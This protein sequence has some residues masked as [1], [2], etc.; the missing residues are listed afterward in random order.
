M[1]CDYCGKKGRKGLRGG[2]ERGILISSD[3]RARKG[4]REKGRERG[5]KVKT[6]YSAQTQGRCKQDRRRPLPAF[7]L[8]TNSFS[9]AKKNGSLEGES[10]KRRRKAVLFRLLRL[11]YD[12]H[13]SANMPSRK[14]EEEKEERELHAAKG[15]KGPSS[16]LPTFSFVAPCVVRRRFGHTSAGGGETNEKEKKRTSEEVPQRN[17]GKP[18]FFSRR[19][20]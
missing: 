9:G 15:G 18:F 19:A 14:K 1:V 8:G 2:I 4:E 6:Y 7:F 10:G 13:R 3:E 12:K 16:S 11:L 5:K 20:N 17:A